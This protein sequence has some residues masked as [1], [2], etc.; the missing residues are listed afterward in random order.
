MP[1]RNGGHACYQ[2]LK[3]WQ[4]HLTRWYGCP[5]FEDKSQPALE[6]KAFCWCGLG[7]AAHESAAATDSIVE[8][9][10]LAN[11]NDLT[12]VDALQP[13]GANG[14]CTGGDKNRLHSK[15]EQ[16]VKAD[17]HRCALSTDGSVK[18]GSACMLRKE[19]ISPGCAYCFGLT[20]H[21]SAQHCLQECACGDSIQ[22]ENCMKLI[23]NPWFSECAGFTPQF[24]LIQTG[25]DDGTSS[26]AAK[27]IT[28]NDKYEH[29]ERM[30]L[31]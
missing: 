8:A 26:L 3:V 4:S 2:G 16:W 10:Q 18:Q 5:Q 31:V 29:D 23:C 30:V 9:A 1:R 13:P 15:G 24:N 11:A 27:S 20:I 25:Q 7:A 21:C 17:M 6:S 14:L 12:V 22:C 28:A 19:W